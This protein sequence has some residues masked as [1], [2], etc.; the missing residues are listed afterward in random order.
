MTDF[1]NPKDGGDIVERI[2]KLTEG[3]ADYSFECIG[4]TDVMRQALECCHKGWGEQ[5]HY[6]RGRGGR[7]NQHAAV[8]AGH[9]A[10]LAGHRPL[11]ARAGAPTC[12]RSWI[13]T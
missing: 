9:R 13:G 4:K 10:Q 3:G 5:H 7:G 11:A 12:P 8:P 1:L 6:R 2:V